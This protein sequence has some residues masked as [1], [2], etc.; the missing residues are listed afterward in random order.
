MADF[1]PSNL[2]GAKDEFSTLARSDLECR[3][4][5]THFAFG[6]T[7]KASARTDPKDYTKTKESLCGLLFNCYVLCL[8][9]LSSNIPVD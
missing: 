1:S 8:F 3:R 6:N 2:P 5:L 9:L 4:C 7:E